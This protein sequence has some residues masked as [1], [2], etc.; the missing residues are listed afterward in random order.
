MAITHLEGVTPVY[1]IAKLVH[2]TPV[3]L[4]FMAMK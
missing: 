1:E 4:G 3:S 2:I